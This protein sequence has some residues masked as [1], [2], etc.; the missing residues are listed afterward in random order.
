MPVRARSL[1]LILASLLAP[2]LAVAQAPAPGG[3][4]A[5]APS[6]D[7][8]VEAPGDLRELLERHLE[9]R[10]YREVSDLDDV[11]IQ[12]LIV[13]AERDARQLLGTRG[14]F[15][16][17]IRIARDK[18][19]S[20][21]RITVAVEPGTPA[22][23]DKVD[24]AFEGAITAE[25]RGIAQQ[26]EGIRGGW[27][28]PVG[29]RFTQQDW[30][31]AKRQALQDL[32]ARRF[33]A[34]RIEYSL[35]DVDAAANKAS[36][37]L[38]L[39]SGPVYRL[40]PMQVTGIEKYDPV[41][42]PRFSQLQ[43]G[44]LYDRNELV[45]AQLRLTGSGYFDSA[46]LLVDPDGDPA[47]APVQVAVREAPLQRLVLGVGVTTDVGPRTTVEHTH[48]RLPL[49][50]W[51][52]VSKLDLNRKTPLI[53]A[54]ATSIPDD[55]LWRWSVLGRTGRVEDDGVLTHGQRLR[56]GRIKSW[57]HIDRNYYLQ[58]DR[59][60]A[61]ADGSVFVAP[62]ELGTG[63]ALSANYVW[64]GRY[65]DSDLLPTAGYGIT[66]ELGGGITLAG[67]RSVFLRPMAHGLMYRPM[68]EG[69]LQFRA[70]LGAVI[71]RKSALLPA[72]L[73]YR[74][75][76]DTTV[77][78]YKYH[79]IGVDLAGGRTGPGRYLAS[80]SVEW[81]RPLRI[82]GNASDFESVMFVD[83]GAVANRIGDLKPRVGVGGGVRWRSPVGPLDV[84]L[85][86]GLKTQK[87]RLHLNVGVTF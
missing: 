5:N 70:E 6:F 2:A 54:E 23:I 76:G 67:D 47:A 66:G 64:T 46:F 53:Q 86:Y 81:Q 87:L 17:T 13:L 30:D 79:E 21:P 51:R 48:N 62:Q 43:P 31:G 20:R 39:N 72:T 78:G 55:D 73:L 38:R 61:R 74:T 3:V 9:L 26:R 50:G 35:A 82:R 18:G 40:G 84:A 69:R 24:I 8:V 36:L 71:A 27:A 29:R 52:T 16:P 11:E 19:P 44:S 12:R 15:S 4:D 14:Y 63:S 42:V 83:A 85:G 59:A 34:G 77:R 68:K 22:A 57:R 75:G 80:G 25:E 56:M 41:L 1:L 58:Y 7:L 32:T 65:F 49:V 33:L 28:L 10:R 37:S 45:E 60:T